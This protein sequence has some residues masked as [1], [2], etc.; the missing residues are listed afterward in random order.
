MQRIEQRQRNF[1]GSRLRICKLSPAI[2]R[3]RL[4]GRFLFGERQLEP[5][6]G[7]QMAVGYVMHDLAH[8]PSAGTVGR[9]ELVLRQSFDGHAQ[10][11]RGLSDIVEESALPVFSER[12]FVGELA[13]GIAQV[14]H[15]VFGIHNYRNLT[16]DAEKSESSWLTTTAR[17]HLYPTPFPPAA[18]FDSPCLHFGASKEGSWLN[19]PCR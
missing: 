11:G 15:S 2:F 6:V 3:V 5:R 17:A 12:S 1:Q 10:L 4:N 16:P 8:S 13:D 18:N 7:V 19:P 9:V 14:G